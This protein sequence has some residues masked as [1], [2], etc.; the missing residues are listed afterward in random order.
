MYRN[1]IREELNFTAGIGDYLLMTEQEAQT[2]LASG[3]HRN[4]CFLLFVQVQE[5]I[6]L[7][8]AGRENLTAF[9]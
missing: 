9:R 5:G 6:F 8:R 3:F 7:R 2:G 4:F 1:A